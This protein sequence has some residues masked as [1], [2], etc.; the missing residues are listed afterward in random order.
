MKK[1]L[2]LI[3]FYIFLLGIL[4][5][6]IL[7]FSLIFLK[8]EFIVLPLNNSPLLITIAYLPFTIWFLLTG[9]GVIL[10]R[11]LARY[12]LIIMSYFMFFIGLVMFLTFFL[13]P[14]SNVFLYKG[15]KI[16]LLTFFTVFF[17]ILPLFFLFFLNSK[18]VKTLF[19][20]K[21]I[22]T[23]V[24]KPFGIK[25]ISVFN[26]LTFLFFIFYVFFPF[27]EIPITNAISISGFTLSIYSLIVAFLNLYI[28]ILL[29]RL[30]KIGWIIS[31]VYYAFVVMFLTL[32]ILTISDNTL[33]EIANRISDVNPII[34]V[35]SYRISSIFINIFSIMV[36]IYLSSRKKLF[37][38]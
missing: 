25:I 31:V 37:R 36:L 23:E 20:I 15:P 38:Y 2:F 22:K 9:I 13:L 24:E 11:N 29:I 1:I 28:A 26:F 3:G 14:E 17:M 16:I 30:K 33:Y 6:G 19:S 27:I 21:Q 32:S 8:Q 18:K 35:L 4:S 12:S 5:G 34:Y 10:R 7:L